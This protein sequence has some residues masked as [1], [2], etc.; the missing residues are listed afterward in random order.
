MQ[1]PLLPKFV[2]IYYHLSVARG[3]WDAGG[4]VSRDYW[5]FAPTGRPHLYPPF[6][7]VLLL[8][9]MQMGV[10]P[11]II[12]RVVDVMAY[13]MLLISFWVLVRRISGE[14][15]AFY[16]LLLF[17]SFYTAYLSAVTLTAFNLGVI[18]WLWAIYF[19]SYKKV[20]LSVWAATAV[21]YTHTLAAAMMAGSFV[22][23]ALLRAESR[24]D[25]LRALGVSLALASPLLFFQA[26]HFGSTKFVPLSQEN[27]SIELDIFLIIAALFY[28]MGRKDSHKADAIP[29]SLLGAMLPM[30]FFRQARILGGHGVLVVA[31][32]AALG[33]QVCT[34]RMR[35]GKGP[36]VAAAMGVVLMLFFVFLA[37]TLQKNGDTGR[38]GLQWMDRAMVRYLAPDAIRDFKPKGF[39]I[40]FKK[41]YDE[42]V[43]LLRSH[44]KT[45]DI[46][47][48]DFPHA[49]GILHVYSGYPMSTAM[50]EEVGD[51]SDRSERL[52][53][54]RFLIWFK[55]AREKFPKD[56]AEQIPKMNLIPIAETDM[57]Y[58]WENPNPSTSN[59]LPKPNISTP[60]LYGLLGLWA[61]F[62][63]LGIVAFYR[64]RR[65]A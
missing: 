26:I 59:P 21:F 17:S 3:F 36:R 54:A 6:L 47:W 28:T 44:A 13:P 40:Y 56:M 57:V 46:F 33:I 39:S 35:T 48:T 58:I 24:I 27:R 8:I 38:W 11:I 49:G 18:G 50:M 16:A 7:H 53:N 15:A 9:P 45:G 29:L 51:W 62:G 30:V 10:E 12:A 14:Q 65:V 41:E 5:E 22:V 42:I 43:S 37:P 31:W 23:Y 60:I 64:H 63:F 20:W 32:L 1:W 55:T 25:A 2:D 4:W 19:L 52:Q 61:C 34:D